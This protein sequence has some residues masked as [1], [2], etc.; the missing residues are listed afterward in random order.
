MNFHFTRRPATDC[1][2]D[3]A[4][5]QCFC[6]LFAEEANGLYLLSFLLTAD[7][8]KAEQCFAASPDDCVRGGHFS[9][10]VTFMG[11]RVIAQNAIQIVAPHGDSTR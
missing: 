4:T 7:H 10:V 3:Y 11:Q 9:R 8:R 2:N 6:D 5:S 1:K